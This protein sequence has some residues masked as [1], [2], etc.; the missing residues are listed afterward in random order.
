MHQHGCH[1]G[2]YLIDFLVI[3]IR[4]TI[5]YTD[6]SYIHSIEIKK[7]GNNFFFDEL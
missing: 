7:F 4:D 2:V 6:L 1:T 3:K 5:K